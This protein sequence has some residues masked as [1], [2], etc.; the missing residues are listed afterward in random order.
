MFELGDKIKCIRTDRETQNYG[1][2]N[3]DLE[4][5]EVDKVYTVSNS[6]MFSWHTLVW[7]EEIEGSFNDCLFKLSE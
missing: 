2:A 6:V 4:S 1:N 5:I 3:G 7:L